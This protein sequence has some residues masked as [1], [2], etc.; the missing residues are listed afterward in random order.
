MI[1]GWIV[2]WII[3]EAGGFTEDKLDKGYKARTDSRLS[4]IDAA[5][6][7]IFPYPGWSIFQPYL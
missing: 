6:W 3:T 4:G 7:F 2:S 1:V 5:D